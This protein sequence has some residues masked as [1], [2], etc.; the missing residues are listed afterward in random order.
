MNNLITR[1]IQSDIQKSLFQGKIVVIYGVR[2]VGK[3]TLVKEIIKNNDA[4][5]AYLNCDEPDIREALTKKTSTELKSYIGSR[6]LVVIDE[7]QR[8]ENIGLTL[9]LIADNFPQMQIIATG[10]SSFELSGKIAEPLTGRKLEFF[11]YPFSVQELSQV[12]SPIEMNRLLEERMVYGMYP[13]IIFDGLDREKRVRELATSYAYKDVLMYQDIR[14]P[15][16]L[17]KLLRALALQIGSEVSYTELAKTLEVNKATIV[18]Y[19]RILEQA[20]IVFRVG[21][22]SR[23][24]RNELKKKRK[25]YFYDLGM[26]NALINNLNPLSLRQDV[27]ALWEN[28]LMSERLKRNTNAQ[29]FAN[30]FFWRTTNGKEIDYIEEVNGTLAGYE[31]K[32]KK[33][34]FSLPR[35]FVRGYPGV[36]V[37][38]VNRENYLEFVSK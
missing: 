3:T 8:V 16:L 34:H 23:N 32:W 29:I 5:S 2:Q 36:K 1:E 27:G 13:G 31:F 7:A 4:D 20:Y 37:D 15:E 33:E 35:E 28:F 25:I 26:R 30:M 19:I 38:I 12:Y 17:E 9:K 6:K 24:V 10:S 22:F 11:L 21:P 14:N 18:S